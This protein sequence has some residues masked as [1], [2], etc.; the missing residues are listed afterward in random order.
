MFANYLIGLREGLEAALIVAILAAYL[1]R[2]GHADR[3][4]WL[5]AGVTLAVVLSLGFGG[6]LTLTSHTLTFEA[7]EI[8]GG[9]GSIVAVALVTTMVFWMRSA[10]RDLGGDLRAKADTALAGGG[11]AMALVGFVAVGREGIETA[12]FLWAAITSGGGTTSP[13]VGAGLGLLT[14]V[15]LGHLFYRGGIRL[16]LGRFFTVSGAALVVVAAGVLAYGVGDLQEA[17]V[18]P[19]LDQIAFDVSA[20]VPED[21][22]YGTLLK[23]TVGFTARTT[24]LQ[25]AAWVLYCPLV[26]ALYLRPHRDASRS[27][28]QQEPTAA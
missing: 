12:L 19:G 3:L 23:G 9:T 24:W 11:W 7:Q 15:V 18:L 13:A 26:L 2:S 28:T 17:A 10:A 14:A 4:R 5:F 22:W 1:V 16:N 27:T 20:V 25:A 21:S 6:A 8:F